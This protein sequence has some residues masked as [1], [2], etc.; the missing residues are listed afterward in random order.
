MPVRV[1]GTH[2]L[3]L[4]ALADEIPDDDVPRLVDAG[5]LKLRAIC[6]MSAHIT[7]PLE[8]APEQDREGGVRR[9]AWCPDCKAYLLWLRGARGEN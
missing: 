8:P 5:E 4:A 2:L 6:P 9:W 1:S 7:L 3:H